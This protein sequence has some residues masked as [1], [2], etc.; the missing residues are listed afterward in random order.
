MSGQPVQE[1]TEELVIS[2][3]PAVLQQST[4]SNESPADKRSIIE[5]SSAS[6]SES[7]TYFTRKMETLGAED[8][9]T[10]RT[11]QELT[12]QYKTSASNTVSVTPGLN[13]LLTEGATLEEIPQVT[14]LDGTQPAAVNQAIFNPAT[15]A[16]ESQETVAPSIS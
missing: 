14:F 9:F 11:D 5:L 13:V 8:P 4:E 6:E 1:D 16:P 2:A 12:E 15:E 10:C 3:P 7:G